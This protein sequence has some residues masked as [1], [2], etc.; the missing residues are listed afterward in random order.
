MARILKP[1]VR[2]KVLRVASMA[3]RRIGEAIGQSIA[4]TRDREAEI[5]TSCYQVSSSTSIAISSIDLARLHY[6]PRFLLSY[7]PASLRADHLIVAFGSNLA[8][9][10]RRTD[11]HFGRKASLGHQLR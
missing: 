10:R 11:G 6:L 2:R 1:T 5:P 4:F 7:P 3:S 8:V 9:P